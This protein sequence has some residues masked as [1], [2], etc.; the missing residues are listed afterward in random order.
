M[1]LSR[2]DSME[3]LRDVVRGTARGAGA[4]VFVLVAAPLI[5]LGV[6]AFWVWAASQL[7][8]SDAHLSVSLALFI[9][10]G[11]LVSY[12]LILL[13]A[14]RLRLRFVDDDE[15]RA[16]VKRMSWNRSMRDEPLRPGDRKSD[17]IERLFMITAIVGFIAFEIWFMTSA[18]SPLG[19]A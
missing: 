18:G 15:A 7:A 10:T 2:E 16:K 1:Y 4:A 17:P 8:A 12:W 3:T 5:G 11:I 14:S 6:P 9:T 13:V 19:P